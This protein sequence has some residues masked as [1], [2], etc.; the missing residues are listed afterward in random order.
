ML[1][2][3]RR[4]GHEVWFDESTGDRAT[5]CGQRRRW[6]GSLGPIERVTWTI[7][8]AR[9]AALLNKDNW[10]HYPDAMLRAR[11][12]TA[13][14]R[15]TFSDVLMGAVYAPEELGARVGAGGEVLS[16]PTPQEA[17]AAAGGL[18]GEAA[19][20]GG[21]PAKQPP[22][23]VDDDPAADLHPDTIEGET[24]AEAEPLDRP[25]LWAELLDQA[26]LAGQS[27]RAFTNRWAKAHRKNIDEATTA[28][29]AEFVHERR[30][31]VDDIVQANPTA[32]D[33]VPVG[34]QPECPVD[35]E[36][37]VVSG[38]AP[39]SEGEKS[40][41]P[42]SSVEDGGGTEGPGNPDAE[43]AASP[44]DEPAPEGTEADDEQ[45]PTVEPVDEDPR[46]KLDAERAEPDGDDDGA[47]LPIE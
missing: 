9:A 22:V 4:Q 7:E 24:V 29:L 37:G 3:I 5:I 32:R 40:E 26:R 35:P 19:E 14:A 31:F 1:A 16:M 44:V 46:A 8:M 10:K 6:D 28:E 47:Q 41:V 36:T 43:P 30:S 42:A 12:T 27:Y 34:P 20:Q 38:P 17:I 21:A 25:A 11:A 23:P 45:Q 18:A 15:M 2:L 33:N 13:L 39:S